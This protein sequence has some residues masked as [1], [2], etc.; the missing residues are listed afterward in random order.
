MTELPEE[1]ANTLLS[2]IPAKI[3]LSTCCCVSCVKPAMLFHCSSNGLKVRVDP[4]WLHQGLVER[5]GG[6]GYN[7]SI[8]DKIKSCY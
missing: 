6:G 8:D 3:I 2:F 5:K 7:D 4:Q 1:L